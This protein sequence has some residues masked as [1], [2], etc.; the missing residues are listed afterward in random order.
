MDPWPIRSLLTDMIFSIVFSCWTRTLDLISVYL[1]R[2]GIIFQRIDGDQVLTQRK[3]N[4][5]KFISD[6]TIPVLLMSTGVGAFG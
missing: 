1:R 5:D 6:R 2:N 3:S 4:M